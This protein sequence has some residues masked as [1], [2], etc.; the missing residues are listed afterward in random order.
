MKTRFFI[1]CLLFSLGIVGV[2][3][4]AQP[5]YGT[6]GSSVENRRILLLSTEWLASGSLLE[7]DS[8]HRGFCFRLGSHPTWRAGSPSLLWV[9]DDREV[10]LNPPF[11][12]F[13]C[14]LADLT[15]SRL[16]NS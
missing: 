5:P 3:I 7:F 11:G 4:T 14:Y 8:R 6:R 16:L 12:V 15:I 13:Y 10:Q 2:A 9:S 1:F